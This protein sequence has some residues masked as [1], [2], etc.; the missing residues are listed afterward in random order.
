M[1][2]HG[3]WPVANRDFINVAKKVNLGEKC[4]I[5]TKCCSYPYPEQKGVVRGI[6]HIGGYILEKVSDIA[7]KVIYISDVDLMGSIPG[8]VKK[9]VSKK[10]GEVAS[11][12]EAEMKKV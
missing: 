11:R 4:I 10:Q 5:A 6:C 8:M 2:Y 3:I 7:T 12:V 9:Q 1:N